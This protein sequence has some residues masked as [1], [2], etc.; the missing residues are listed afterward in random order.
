[1]G[2]DGRQWSGRLDSWGRLEGEGAGDNGPCADQSGQ[3]QPTLATA[4]VIKPLQGPG[5]P[6]ADNGKATEPLARPARA[7]YLSVLIDS[8]RFAS[9]SLRVISNLLLLRF[10][11]APLQSATVFTAHARRLTLQRPSSLPR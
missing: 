4:A 5:F 2:V 3:R 9:T 11:T 1:M 6:C 7:G 8:H 10:R